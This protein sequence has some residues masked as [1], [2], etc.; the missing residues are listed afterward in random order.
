MNIT[1]SQ[2]TYLFAYSLLL[3]VSIL[4]GSALADRYQLS[5]GWV[6]VTYVLVTC[7]FVFACANLGEGA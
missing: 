3:M 2:V 5:A 4:V 1:V 6:A 7:A